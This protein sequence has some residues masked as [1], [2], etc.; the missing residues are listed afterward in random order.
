MAEYKLANGLDAKH[1]YKDLTKTRKEVLDTARE[2]AEISIPFVFPPEGYRPGDRLGTNNQSVNSDMVKTLATKLMYA[3]F[4]PS[5]PFVRYDISA[6]ALAQSARYGDDP[7]LISKTKLGLMKRS[8]SHR[9]RLEAV[10]MRSAYITFLR[11]LIIGG[12]SCFDYVDIENPVVRNLANYVVRR[13]DRGNQ[14]LV[15]AEK[16]VLRSDLE[17]EVLAE[18]TKR[19]AT[20]EKPKEEARKAR[21]EDTLPVYRVCETDMNAP[22]SRPHYRLWEECEG[23]YIP[24]SGKTFTDGI[25]PLYAGW[26]IPMY[27]EDYGRAYCDLYRGDLWSI[28]NSHA[29]LQDI[30]G[31]LARFITMVRPGGLTKLS[32]VRGA[33]NNDVIIGA[34]EEV[35]SYQAGKAGDLQAL[36]AYAQSVERRL[37]RGFGSTF[38]VQRDAER[39]TR[40]EWVQ[41]TKALDEAMG[42]LHAQFSQ[43]GQKTVVQMFIRL[44]EEEE[45][46]GLAPLPKDVVNMSVITGIDAYGQ[47]T[48]ASALVE[49][50]ST[51]NEMLSPQRAA[52]ITSDEEWLQRYTASKNITPDGLVKDA[53]TVQ[54]ESEDAMTQGA[55][56]Q[57]AP[58]MMQEGAKQLFASMSQAQAPA[59]PAQPPA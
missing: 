12:N 46:S 39:V 45:S 56:A 2:L 7:A 20:A 29:A 47:D 35:Q 27:G 37:G 16:Q 51:I 33:S 53:D 14:L 52:Q 49:W 38:A 41:L 25:P 34:A 11:E 23:V 54:Q 40:E 5:L 36:T 21:Y 43:T 1:T 4:P 57:A 58:G 9:E 31:G 18:V 17:E 26:L 48:E 13:D 24:D 50:R 30:G 44:H 10:P 15:I 28:E 32:D 19:G 59:G 3:A 42:G 6:M 8:N 22:Y 55:V